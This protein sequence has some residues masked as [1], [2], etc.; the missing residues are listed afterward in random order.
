MIGQ[1]ILGEELIVDVGVDGGGDEA[2][3]VREEA[4]NVCEHLFYF[5]HPGRNYVYSV[6]TIVESIRGLN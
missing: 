4:E 5:H 2:N 6:E 1:W 3:D